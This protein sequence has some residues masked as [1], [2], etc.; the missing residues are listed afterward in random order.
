MG[1]GSRKG[2]WVDLCNL[3]PIEGQSVVGDRL[4]QAHKKNFEFL[5]QSPIFFC[6]LHSAPLGRLSGQK[7][8]LSRRFFL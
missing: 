7:I 2:C 8:F 6:C 1:E 5:V 4:L 3:T